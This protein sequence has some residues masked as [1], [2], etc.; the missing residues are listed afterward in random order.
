M[1]NEVKKL[2]QGWTANAREK[3]RYNPEWEL[4]LGFLRTLS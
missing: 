3:I 1:H 2:V 4:N